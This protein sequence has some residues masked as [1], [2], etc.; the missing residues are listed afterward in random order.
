MLTLHEG[1]VEFY[2]IVG[3]IGSKITTALTWQIWV[4]QYS[5][6]EA[7]ILKGL[8]KTKEPHVRR[9]VCEEQPEVSVDA[10]Q[11]N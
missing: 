7:D 11:L 5:A 1:Y 2:R 6:Y 10:V 8:T 4:E 3:M 9:V